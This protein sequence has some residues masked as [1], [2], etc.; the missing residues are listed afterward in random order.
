MLPRSQPPGWE[1]I[2]RGS[3]SRQ[4]TGGGAGVAKRKVSIFYY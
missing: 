3:T 2:L 4:A 1:C